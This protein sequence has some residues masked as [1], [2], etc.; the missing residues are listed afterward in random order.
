MTDEKKEEEPMRWIRN[1]LVELNDDHDGRRAILKEP[2]RSN[3]YGY[4]VTC[5]L[6]GDTWTILERL[7]GRELKKGQRLRVEVEILEPKD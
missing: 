6:D 3:A 7:A 2:V 5:I 1:S 4:D